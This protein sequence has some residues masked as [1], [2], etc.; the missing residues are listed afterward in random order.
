MTNENNAGAG[1]QPGNRKQLGLILLIAG[2]SLGG[3]YLLFLFAG[4]G[5][6]WGTTN[7]GAFVAPPRT[8]ASLDLRDES[9]T[10]SDTSGSWWLWVLTSRTCAAECEQALHRLRQLHILLN[11]DA[12]RV[13]RALVGV[14]GDEPVGSQRGL[15]ERYPELAVFS[16]TPDGLKAGVYIVDPIGNLVLW[17]PLGDAGA[18]VLDDLKRLLKVSQIG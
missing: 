8:V 9:D 1:A 16:A 11:K 5:A 3:A 7:R 12:G 14:G 2:A 15:R 18:P 17:Y 13:R 4:D 10:P 6:G